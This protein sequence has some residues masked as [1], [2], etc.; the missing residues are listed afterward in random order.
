[1]NALEKLYLF[2]KTLNMND[3]ND[4]KCYGVSTYFIRKL[5]DLFF[6]IIGEKASINIPLR[7]MHCLLKIATLTCLYRPIYLELDD[8]P[9][10]SDKIR[11]YWDTH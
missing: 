9:P 2:V 5:T 1:M 10:Y 4:E 6:I 7:K 11:Y 8:Y 3:E